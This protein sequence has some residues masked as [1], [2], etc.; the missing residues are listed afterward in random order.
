MAWLTL[1]FGT[2]V[3]AALDLLAVDSTE[4]GNQWHMTCAAIA[5]A[6]VLLRD[7]VAPRGIDPSTCGGRSSNHHAARYSPAGDKPATAGGSRQGMH[8]R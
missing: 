8:R 1:I 2:A 6:F 5:A 7:C 4:P 3:A